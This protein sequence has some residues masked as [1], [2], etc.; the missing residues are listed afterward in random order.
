MQQTR[1][2]SIN[3]RRGGRVLTLARGYVRWS[4]EEYIRL[5]CFLF[6]CFYLSNKLVSM[7]ALSTHPIS[8]TPASFLIFFKGMPLLPPLARIRATI[9]FGGLGWSVQVFFKQPIAST[10]SSSGWAR[11]GGPMTSLIIAK[12]T[13]LNCTRS[14]RLP[15]STEKKDITRSLFRFRI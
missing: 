4:A 6:V 12:N 2:R 11:L 15:T 7:A 8:G 13:K 14:R 5:W 10:L 1:T 3:Q 9:P